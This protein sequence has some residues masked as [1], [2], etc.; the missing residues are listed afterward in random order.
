MIGGVETAAG[1]YPW[2][3]ALSYNGALGSCS[4]TLISS[5]WAITAAHCIGAGGPTSLVLGEHDI[6]SANDAFDTNR[7]VDFSLV[8]SF[9]SQE[10]GFSVRNSPPRLRRVHSK[11]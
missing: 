3:A 10:G 7:Q 2:I 6:S 8:S 9:L 5:N 4:G 1:V 11:Q